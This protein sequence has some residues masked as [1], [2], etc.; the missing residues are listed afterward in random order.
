MTYNSEDYPEPERFK[1]DRFIKDG[2]L[3]PDVRDPSTL[4]F[5]FGRRFV[6]IHYVLCCAV[7]LIGL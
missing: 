2:R 6:F 5:G 4:V 1:P 7:I 3:D